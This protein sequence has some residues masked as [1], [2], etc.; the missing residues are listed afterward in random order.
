MF[1]FKHITPFDIS[2]A[3]APGPMVLFSTPGIFQIFA[4]FETF[5]FSG[6]L[7]GGQ[8]L[9][10]FKKWCGEERNMIIMP[11]YCVAGTIGAKVINGVKKIEID[12]RNVR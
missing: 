1:E 10:V 5:I 11:G 7:H 9:R 4:L 3:D 8:S 2:Y 12:G 6:M